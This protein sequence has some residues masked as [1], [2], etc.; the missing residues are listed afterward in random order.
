MAPTPLTLVVVAA[1]G[2]SIAYLSRRLGERAHARRFLRRCGEARAGVAGAPIGRSIALRGVVRATGDGVAASTRSRFAGDPLATSAR[3]SDL[4]LL[5][6]DGVVDLCGSV[7]VILGAEQTPTWLASNF[8][9]GSRRG[10]TRTL[11]PGDR[12]IATGVLERGDEFAG[13]REPGTPQ[14]SLRGAPGEDGRPGAI[15]L[16]SVSPPPSRAAAPRALVAGAAIAVG[17][18]VLVADV[19]VPGAT[20]RAAERYACQLHQLPTA[21]LPTIAGAESNA[22]PASRAG[23]PTELVCQRDGVEMVFELDAELAPA[24]PGALPRAVAYDDGLRARLDF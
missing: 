2:A 8:I 15:E 14:W 3:A 23:L 12:V 22:A 20:A 6:E 1:A 5:V 7:E 9:I 17:L 13:Y 4:Q 11:R 18:L 19:D 16:T 10:M 24:R 21:D